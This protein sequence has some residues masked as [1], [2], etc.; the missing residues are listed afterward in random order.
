MAQLSDNAPEVTGSVI[1]DV[2]EAKTMRHL[3]ENKGLLDTKGKLY[4]GTGDTT[5]TGA[6]VTAAV[7]PEGAADGAV[8]VKDS[9]QNAGWKVGL[10]ESGSLADGAVGTEQIAGLAVT[11]EKIAPG[12]VGFGQLNEGDLGKIA[13]LDRDNTFRS[14]NTFA[15]ASKYTPF[16]GQ[17]LISWVNGQVTVSLAAP[18]RRPSDGTHLTFLPSKTGQILSIPTY[19]DASATQS[20]TPNMSLVI[21]ELLVGHLYLLWFKIRE[22]TGGTSIVRRFTAMFYYP[23]VTSLEY[24]MVLTRHVTLNSGYSVTYYPA[25]KSLDISL[26][27]PTNSNFSA[28]FVGADGD[29]IRIFDLGAEV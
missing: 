25:T 10:L 2:Q 28:S 20:E 3:I 5:S 7:D 18:P 9:T 1:P 24:N 23:G 6:P 4:A 19:V 21:P 11:T 12:A 17:A 13:R 16:L 22:T 8:L 29:S 14:G 26:E 27:V 15:T